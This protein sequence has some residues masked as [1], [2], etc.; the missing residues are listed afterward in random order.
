MIPLRLFQPNAGPHEGFRSAGLAF[1]LDAQREPLV[2]PGHDLLLG[3]LNFLEHERSLSAI[4]S[5]R[6]LL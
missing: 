2:H 3:R 1:R 6:S 4:L 5:H